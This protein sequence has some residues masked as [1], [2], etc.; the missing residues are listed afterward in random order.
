MSVEKKTGDMIQALDKILKQR[1]P[2]YGKMSESDR[3]HLCRIMRL[4]RHKKVFAEGGLLAF[5]NAFLT[6]L[7][8][9]IAMGR[10]S[11]LWL[12]YHFDGKG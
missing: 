2:D 11:S 3:F 4:E 1:I 7:G 6:S 5:A 9:C 8:Y 12:S 10:A